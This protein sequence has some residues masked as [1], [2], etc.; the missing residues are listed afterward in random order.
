MP[1]DDFSSQI[2]SLDRSQ[3]KE[4]MLQLQDQTLAERQVGGGGP[5]GAHKSFTGSDWGQVGTSAAV[6]AATGATV[7]SVVPILGTAVGGVVGGVAGAGYGTYRKFAKGKKAKRDQDEYGRQRA[8]AV[9]QQQQINAE[10]LKSVRHQL[11]TLDLRDSVNQKFQDMDLGSM[12]DGVV[13]KGLDSNILGIAQQHDDINRETGF[14]T[15]AR[16]LGGGSF[17]ATRQA[18]IQT[19]QDQ[20]VAQAAAQAQSQRSQL[21]QQAD[22]QRRQL[23]DSIS[24][25]NPGEDA[26]VQNEIQGIGQNA[27]AF[28]QSAQNSIY[29]SA[30]QQQQMAGQSQAL[31]GLLS[32]Y[33]NLYTQTDRQNNPRGYN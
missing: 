10:R 11:K 8:A 22:T 14:G 25:A 15:V 12:F 13:K 9:Q 31:G 6:G 16:G 30:L 32:N 29:G 2:G 26:R 4:L 3:L 21:G 27:S 18:D 28:G 17:D 24:G 1:N 23:L 20:A 7:G 19:S 33:A 5:G